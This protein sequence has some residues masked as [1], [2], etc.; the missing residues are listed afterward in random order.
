MLCISHIPDTIHYIPYIICHISCNSIYH[1]STINIYR[2]HLSG[3]KLSKFMLWTPENVFYHSNWCKCLCVCVCVLERDRVLCVWV[4]VWL[5]NWATWVLFG[6]CCLAGPHAT[7][8]IEFIAFF[9]TQLWGNFSTFALTTW[10]IAAASQTPLK[11]D[12][13]RTWTAI[14]NERKRNETRTK[15]TF[16]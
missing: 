12:C 6:I 10:Q 14:D 8:L 7:H 16:Q 4:C 9:G 3:V 5:L 1:R 2:V 13:C 11:S 15:E